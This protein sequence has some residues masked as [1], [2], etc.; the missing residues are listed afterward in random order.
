MVFDLDHLDEAVIRQRARDDEP[1]GLER[2]AVL[3]VDFVAMAM[4]LADLVRAIRFFGM[5]ALREDA[6]IRAEAHRA[7]LVLDALLRLHE[8][9]DRMIRLGVELRAVRV[10]HTADVAGELDDSTL[11][12]EAEAEERDVMLARVPYYIYNMNLL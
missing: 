4:A 2:R 7:A 8:V 5:R 3:V 10:R 9:D 1:L 6:G 11:H 12:A